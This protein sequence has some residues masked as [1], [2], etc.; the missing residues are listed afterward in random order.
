M[1]CPNG[2]DTFMAGHS[3]KAKKIARQLA[4]DLGFAHCYDFGARDKAGLLEQL[5]LCWN[6]WPIFKIWEALSG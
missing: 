5:A 1:A 3:D 4:V 2:L 6:S